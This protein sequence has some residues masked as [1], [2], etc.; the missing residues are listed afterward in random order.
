[1]A[2]EKER[3]YG[4]RK[5]YQFCFTHSLKLVM[6]EPLKQNKQKT[7]PVVSRNQT[8]I[9]DINHK[10]KRF[11]KSTIQNMM[12]GAKSKHIYLKNQSLDVIES[13]SKHITSIY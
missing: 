2:E 13:Y 5:T 1:M 12:R 3:N 8:K 9:K 6:K 11:F 10:V 4:R 7:T